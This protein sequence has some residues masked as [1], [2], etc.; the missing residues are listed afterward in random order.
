[1]S[2]NASSKQILLAHGNEGTR[3]VLRSILAD[4]LGHRITAAVSTTEALLQGYR[5]QLPDLVVSSV[6]LEDGDAIECL[7]EASKIAARPSIIVT[8][9]GDLEH[10]E[11]A[12]DDHVMSYLVEPVSVD[13]LRPSIYLVL[14]RFE[15]FQ[16]LRQEVEELQEALRARKIIERAKG[17]LMQ[18][19]GLDEA[20]AF[21]RLQALASSKRKKLVEIAEALLL[22]DE[23]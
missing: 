19:K 16:E 3:Q 7:L 5:E 20:E 12:L 13:D 6:Y 17:M 14:K 23:L 4:E 1:M 9:Q 18:A 2:T 8:T 11:R 21:K 15:E 22:A 10:V